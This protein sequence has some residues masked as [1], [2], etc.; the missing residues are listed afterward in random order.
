[1]KHLCK[2]IPLGHTEER[3][4][5]A[6]GP[7]RGQHHTGGAPSLGCRNQ[8]E[9]P[10]E[11]LC[12]LKPG[13]CLVWGKDVAV[14]RIAAK[15]N[16]KLRRPTSKRRHSVFKV[17]QVMN[18]NRSKNSSR[19]GEA[20]GRNV[21]WEERAVSWGNIYFLSFEPILRLIKWLS[22]RSTVMIPLL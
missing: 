7:W 11:V 16:K 20:L 6:S 12:T 1:M 3:Y 9:L 19:H 10:Q 13:G 14:E 2:M 22:R 21:I 4:R 17:L 15:R 8:E 18:I 5:R